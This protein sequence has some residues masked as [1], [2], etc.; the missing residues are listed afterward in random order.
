MFLYGNQGTLAH[1]GLAQYG[2]KHLMLQYN[3]FLKF[4]R[5]SSGKKNLVKP[6]CEFF[7]F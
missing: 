5:K 1:Y 4:V 3:Q 6:S 7:I 2:L